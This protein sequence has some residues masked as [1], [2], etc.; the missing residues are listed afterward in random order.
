[1]MNNNNERPSRTYK[2]RAPGISDHALYFTVVGESIPE[3]FFINSKELESF[4]WITSLMTSYHRQVKAG[5]PIESI[6]ND[7]KETFDP[8]GLYIIPDGT[9]REVH[10]VVHH[11]GLI[12]EYHCKIIPA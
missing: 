1:M 10:S 7:M 3:A 11:L 2:L 12:L 5:T 9:G 6:I 4:Q 8:N